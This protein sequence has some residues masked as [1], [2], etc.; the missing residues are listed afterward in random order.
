MVCRITVTVRI[1]WR[2]SGSLMFD[3]SFDWNE[4]LSSFLPSFLPSFLRPSLHHN[5][6]DVSPTSY[7]LND[8]AQLR[9][10]PMKM[11][12]AYC[13]SFLCFRVLYPPRSKVYAQSSVLLVLVLVLVLSPSSVYRS[14]TT[15]HAYDCDDTCSTLDSRLRLPPIQA[16]ATRYPST[17]PSSAF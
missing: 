15:A 10:G 5:N 2:W 17:R 16:A 7:L 11:C 8:T 4:T 3:R 1:A 9:T 6:S 13:S 12:T 14:D